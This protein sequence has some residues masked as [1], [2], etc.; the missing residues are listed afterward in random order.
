[1]A[2]LKNNEVWLIKKLLKKWYIPL[3]KNRSIYKIAKMF[4]VGYHTIHKIKTQKH[5]KD[6]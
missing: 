4:N 5:W 2:K 6:I 1:M 3:N